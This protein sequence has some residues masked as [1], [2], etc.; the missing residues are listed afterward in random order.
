M[1]R[2]NINI[3]N[4]TFILIAVLLVIVLVGGFV[5]A[6]NSSP[7]N[8]AYFGHSA[9]EIEG[10]VSW[11]NYTCGYS[12]PNP[13]LCNPDP[14]CKSAGYSSA[15]GVCLDQGYS[16]NNFYYGTIYVNGYTYCLIGGSATLMKKILCIK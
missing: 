15:A 10:G 7:A 3:N 9:N 13:S 14:F 5:F 11:V 12:S 8:P 4:R 2:L 6:Y 16:T 1:V